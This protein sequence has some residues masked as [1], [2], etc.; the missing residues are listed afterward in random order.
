[1]AKCSDVNKMLTAMEGKDRFNLSESGLALVWIHEPKC[2][3]QLNGRVDSLSIGTDNISGSLKR[4]MDSI[5]KSISIQVD[6]LWLSTMKKYRLENV[7]SNNKKQEVPLWQWQMK[8]KQNML[9]NVPI[10][11]IRYPWCANA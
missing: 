5:H 3:C 4:W 11:T 10:E 7:K 2:E 8:F 6:R 1:M 9:S